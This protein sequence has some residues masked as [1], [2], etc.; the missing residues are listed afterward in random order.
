MSANRVI[1]YGYAVENGRNIVH[2]KE[3]KIIRRVFT[4]YLGGGSLLTIAQSLTAEKVEFLPGRS[5]WNKNRVKR[6][7]E[8]ERYLGS[9]TYPAII[10]EDMH[11]QARA[12]K[13]SK[14]YKQI[15][16]EPTFRPACPV[17][18]A[19]CGAKMSRRHDR[20]R[21][22][23]REVWTCQNPDCHAIIGMEDDALQTHITEL[24]NRLIADPGL[25]D[26]EAPRTAEPPEIRRMANEAE[27]ELDAFAF[28]RDKAKQAIFALATEKYNHIDSRPY[29][30]RV[31]R[32][33][34]EDSKLS[35]SELLSF[36][37]PG[38]FKRTV[39]KI[40]LGEGVTR[41][42]LKNQQPIERSEPNADS[43]RH[44]PTA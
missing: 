18:C 29:Q 31:V 40:L 24:L 14:N 11:R 19:L 23:F 39:L 38:L 26:T 33:E 25:I 2:S 41:L 1:P 15:K 16:S 22:K 34:F 8:E 21:K 3:S 6:I 9:D 5:D 28:D 32:A 37:N 7:L 27:R 20:R 13:D 30:G 43:D 36:F 44:D 10:S 12:R 42:I 17:E 4:D 35:S